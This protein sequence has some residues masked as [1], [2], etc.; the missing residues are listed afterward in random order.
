MNTET[1]KVYTG[2]DEIA[3]A[4]ER[5]E[6][7]VPVS[8]RVAKLVK[9]ARHARAHSLRALRRKRDRIEKASRKRNRKANR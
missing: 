1:G 8:P 4:Q 3:A 9:E 5:G 7:L 2:P 6:K